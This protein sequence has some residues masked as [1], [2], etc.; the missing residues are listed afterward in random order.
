MLS[1]VSSS[2]IVKESDISNSEAIQGGA[3][4]VQQSLLNVENGAL[5]NNQAYKDGGAVFAGDSSDT[6]FNNVAANDNFVL[7]PSRTGDISA[8]YSPS[9]APYTNDC[10]EWDNSLVKGSCPN[11]DNA[12][13]KIVFLL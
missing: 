2:V 3:I 10:P 9:G 6:H 8:S 1:S 11:Y 5:F 7:C 12:Y 13:N 4:H